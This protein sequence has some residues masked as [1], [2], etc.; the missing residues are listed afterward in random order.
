M[1]SE[2][3]V[4]ITKKADGTVI[5]AFFDP[6]DNSRPGTTFT[7]TLD[8][9]VT[10]SLSNGDYTTKKPDCTFVSYASS[11]RTATTWKPDGTKITE[12]SD[13][14][15]VMT[16]PDGTTTTDKGGHWYMTFPKKHDGSVSTYY[17]NGTT[18]TKNVDGT[19]IVH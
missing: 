13:G 2:A 11:D 15:T 7:K 4:V 16:T 19:T 9:T 5:T 10:K 12:T 6:A 14:K 17:E 8:G 3:G 18:I 1:S